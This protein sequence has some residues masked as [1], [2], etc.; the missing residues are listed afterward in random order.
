MKHAQVVCL[1]D[2]VEVDL[3]DGRVLA[4]LDGRGVD[5]LNPT[6]MLFTI[7]LVE[8]LSKCRAANATFHY[9]MKSRDTCAPGMPQ[10][11]I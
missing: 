2:I 9:G 7:C 11:E 10:T 3:G 1:G 8:P 4:Q 6:K 5:Q